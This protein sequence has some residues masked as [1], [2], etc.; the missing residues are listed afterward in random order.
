MNATT[1]IPTGVRAGFA[2]AALLGMQ[3]CTTSVDADDPDGAAPS[4][5]DDAAPGSADGASVTNEC[6][7]LGGGSFAEGDLAS[8]WTLIDGAGNNV[9][10]HDSCG[11]VIFFEAGAEW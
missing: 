1:T 10:L 3:A 11:K 6:D 9:S 4:A 5:S 2:L 7:E 8:D